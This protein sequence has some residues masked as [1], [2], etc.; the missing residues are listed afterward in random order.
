[1]SDY[2]LAQP[3][4]TEAGQ[5][6]NA[7]VENNCGV[8]LAEWDHTADGEETMP[9]TDEGGDYIEAPANWKELVQK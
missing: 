4:Y 2:K 5:F 1:M 7:I 8:W 6:A 3:I 9:L